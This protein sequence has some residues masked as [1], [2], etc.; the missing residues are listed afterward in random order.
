MI[1]I[2]FENSNFVVCDKPSGVLS[3]PSR[4]EEDDARLCLGSALQEHLKIQ[5]YPVNRLDFEVSGLVMYAK[6]PEAHRKGNAWFEL[7]QVQKTYRALTSAQDFSHIPDN[8]SN[9]RT[10]F[11]SSV[12][13]QFEWKSLLL[14]GKRR[15]YEHAQ[16]KP[17]LTR[18]T[19]LGEL[20]KNGITFLQWDLQPITGRPHQL[21]FEMS[22]HGFPIVG[23]RLYGST[24]GWLTEHSI[25][26][27]SY[28][29]DFTDTPGAAAL[30]LP[31]KIVVTAL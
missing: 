22:R 8:V 12:G 30:D 14:R 13:Q 16:G 3:T 17:S 7:K 27:R 19:H 4:F 29:I 11:K 23:D 1:K 25:A 9:P 5:I 2:V 24:H 31:L 10:P 26:L 21:R 28:E 6:N 20:S 18:V 15:A